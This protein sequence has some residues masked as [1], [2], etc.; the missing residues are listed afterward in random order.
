MMKK[1]IYLLIC[2]VLALTACS[3]DDNQDNGGNTITIP[4]GENNTP[5]IVNY[6]QASLVYWGIQDVSDESC[7]FELSLYTDMEINY[8]GNPI[9]PGK[10]MRLSMNAPLFDKGTTEFPLPEG[11]YKASPANYI[12]DAWTF[13]TG[14]E[15]QINLPTG[16]IAVNRGTFYGDV[17]P[18]STE[19]E[20]D[21]LNVGKFSIKKNTDGTYSIS[22]WAAG[23]SSRKR[24][25][26]Y[27]G[28]LKTTDR[29]TDVEQI[30]NSTITEDL[31]LTEFTQARLQDK[32]N[33]YY[34][35]EEDRI[36]V[37][38]LYLAEEGVNLE[39]TWPKGS[40]KF[41]KLE[42]F[43]AWET[44]VNA[45]IPAG[46]YTVAE[47]EKE[48][49]GIPKELMKPFNI[50]SGYPNKF[51]YPDGTWYQ[52]FKDGVIDK[53]YARIDKGTMKVTR[54]DDGGHTLTIDFI[55]SDK[56][57]PHHIRCV[58]N[59]TDPIAIFN[60]GTIINE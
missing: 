18:Y 60:D 37:F 19:Y 49:S 12:F 21:L 43:V 30:P 20:A 59:R 42:I 7:H 29:H 50:A 1:W 26:T 45:G 56:E 44:D 2:S 8:D 5:E 17:A 34:L 40:G 48:S 23:N 25:F 11:T 22:G 13:N 4:D 51:T 38:S 53:E 46:T 15:D 10:I 35:D 9:G 24:N 36:R 54:D 3:D 32:G 6:T 39:G 27:T 57:R 16:V 31:S 14:Y 58:Y 52:K 41:L 55:D 33:S 28:E 47:R